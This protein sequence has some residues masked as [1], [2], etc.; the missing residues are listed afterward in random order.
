MVVCICN[1]ISDTEVKKAIESGITQEDFKNDTE[2]SLL[3]GSCL[4]KL[5]ELY[6]E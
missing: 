3:C 6:K 4:N 1:N 2:C 5:E